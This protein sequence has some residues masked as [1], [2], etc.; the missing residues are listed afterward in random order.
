MVV[1]GDMAQYYGVDISLHHE[2]VVT[3]CLSVWRSRYDVSFMTYSLC[4]ILQVEPYVD[5]SKLY[6]Q[7]LNANSA[8]VKHKGK[9]FVLGGT[10]SLTGISKAVLGHPLRKV[11]GSRSFRVRMYALSYG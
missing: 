1:N 11:R 9:R 6:K 4:S 7:L 5:I 8:S 2:I 10:Y 3:F